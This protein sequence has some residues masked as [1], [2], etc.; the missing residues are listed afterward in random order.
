[1]KQETWYAIYT[2]SRY[3]KRVAEDMKKNGYTVYLPLV[4][5]MRQWSD[6][7]KKVEIPLISSY[8]FVRVDA[9]AYYQILNTPGVVGYVTF[10]GKAAPIRDSQIEM[11]R[12][13]VEGNQPVALVQEKLEK[14]T[15]VKIVAGPL[16]GA[17]GDFLTIKQKHNFIIDLSS[18]GFALKVEVNA[19]DVVKL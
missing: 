19:A 15:T 13:A 17:V 2:K 7:K 16:K 1:M 11:M 14:G 6:R 12:N 3:E 9:R 5:T 10:E 8:V 18:I 4:K